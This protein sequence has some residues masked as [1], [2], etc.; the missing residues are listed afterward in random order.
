MKSPKLKLKGDWILI[1]PE[2]VRIGKFDTESIKAGKENGIIK[3]IG[4]D[5]KDKTLKVGEKVLYASWAIQVTN[6]ENKT[7][8][9]IS[10]SRN[11]IMAGV[12]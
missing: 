6:Y 11:G 8:I 1:E 4:P 5:V 2:E 9:F 12:E 7:Y 10:E 3:G